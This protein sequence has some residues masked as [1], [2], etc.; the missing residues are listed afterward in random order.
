MSSWDSTAVIVTRL[1]TGQQMSSWDSTA[2][3]VTRLGTGQQMNSWDSTA[4]IVTRL[5]T[6]Q[7]S[8]HGFGLWHRQTNLSS[9]SVQTGSGAHQA[10]YSVGIGS[11]TWE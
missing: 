4:V 8:N 10:P 6:G 1:G 9:S 3:I 5:G 11:F 2:V 7:L